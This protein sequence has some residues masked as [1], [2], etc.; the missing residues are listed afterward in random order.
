MF[1]Q[2]AFKNIWRNKRRT[3]LAEVSIVF[4]IVV[5]I[6][7]GALTNGMSWSW[8]NSMI[9]EKVGAMQ[10][11]HKDYEKEHM[12]KPLETT[13]TDGKS[14][15]QHITSYPGVTAAFASLELEGMISNGSKSTTFFGKGLD[16]VE[17]RKTLP[18][19][20][21]TIGKGRPLGNNQNEILLGPKLADDLELKLGDPV[22]VLVQ[23]MA[24]GLNMA[25]MIF[26][27]TQS[28]G[29]SDYE[30]A[31]Y[32]EMHL[33]SAQKLMRMPD[34]ISQVVIGFEQFETIRENAVLLQTELDKKVSTPVRVK[35]YTE[36]IPGWEHNQFFSL[37]GIVVG[38]VLFIVVGSGIANTMFMSIMERRKEIGTMKAIGAEQKH[39]KRLFVLEGF[40]IALV[41]AVIGFFLAVAVVFIVNETGGVSFPP[42][43]GSSTPITIPTKLSPNI[44][45][46]AVILSLVVGVIASYLPARISAKL[47]PVVTLREE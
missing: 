16:V 23:T 37:I 4:G 28:G 18:D 44:N 20:E 36:T 30:S 24:G 5:I 25:E 13:L 32:V 7:T 35:D 26:V 42:P 3:I 39:I 47:D 46:F 14:L 29:Q 12:F 43:P 21:N 17:M 41:G 10:V 9:K 11:E 2:I 31:H 19:L 8:A 45:T 22:M 27:G 34:R 15:I 38:I 1:L 40:L 33:N 6:F